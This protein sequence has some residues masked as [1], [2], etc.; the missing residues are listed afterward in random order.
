MANFYTPDTAVYL[1]NTPLNVNKKDTYAPNGWTQSAQLAYFQSCR[2]YTFNDFTFQRKDGTIRVPINIEEL[3]KNGVNYCY[4]RNSHYRGKWFFCF[5]TRL[6]F[7]NEATTALHIKTDVF[8]T[9]YFEMQLKTSFVE[10]E[11]TVTDNMF[12]HTIPEPLPTPE[13]LLTERVMLTPDLKSST[14]FFFDDNYWCGIFTSEAIKHLS[15]N[16]PTRAAFMG[17]VYSPCYIY[18]TDL[19]GFSSFI[20]AVNYSGQADA[21]V[22]CVAIPKSMATYHDLSGY[23]PPDPPPSPGGTN[24]LGSPYNAWFTINRIYDPPNH[25][26]LDMNG[27]G[28][29]EIRYIYSTVSGTV[30]Y[31]NYHQ[32]SYEGGSFGEMICILDDVTGYY[33]LFGHLKSRA[34]QLG[35]TVT[36][37]Q[38]IG[39]EGNTGD[40]EGRHLHYQVSSGD[41]WAGNIDPTTVAGAQYPN[42]VGTYGQ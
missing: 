20:G 39:V 4:Y 2:V 15:D 6:E 34:V 23:D 1:C 14:T 22:S 40:S 3:Y 18:A 28:E 26:G 35:D 31:S 36:R 21:I 19:S 9:W 7:L 33:F 37:G 13:H 24:L 42:A 30:V 8:Q 17:G 5:I 27:V 10:R 25:K 29:G 38:Y 16:V 41:M 32:A 11:H 12:Q